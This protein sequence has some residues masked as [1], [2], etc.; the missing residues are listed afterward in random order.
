MYTI[1]DL[2]VANFNFISNQNRNS[3]TLAIAVRGQ[4][5]FIYDAIVLRLDWVFL[6]RQ[7]MLLFCVFYWRFVIGFFFNNDWILFCTF[8]WSQKKTVCQR[9]P[10]KKLY[11]IFFFKIDFNTFRVHFWKTN[12]YAA[13]K[14]KIE[15]NWFSLLFT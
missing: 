4:F 14:I 7:T 9:I 11:A 15:L 1:F 6:L 13:I 2:E 3:R 5:V 12:N 8:Y 10:K